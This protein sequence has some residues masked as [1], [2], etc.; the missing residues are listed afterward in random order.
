MGSGVK[1]PGFDL[2][3]DCSLDDYSWVRAILL[4]AQSKLASEAG[5]TGV[6]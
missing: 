4:D 2:Q 1:V 3:V 5:H 6:L